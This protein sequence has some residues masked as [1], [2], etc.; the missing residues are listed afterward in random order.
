MEVPTH[1][2]GQTTGSLSPGYDTAVVTGQGPRA[3]VASYP[4]SFLART[5][6]KEWIR[7]AVVFIQLL[8]CIIVI[9]G[10]SIKTRFSDSKL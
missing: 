5:I 1:T 2:M 10:V 9:Q 4:S 7:L 6:Y 8:Q 3:R